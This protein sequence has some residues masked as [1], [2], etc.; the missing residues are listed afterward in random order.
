MNKFVD[1]QVEMEQ[2]VVTC[3]NME[4]PE[5]G[6][7]FTS[8]G[9]SA[10]GK[11]ESAADHDT[12]MVI[13]ADDDIHAVSRCTTSAE[14]A[15]E[16][17]DEG[18]TCLSD[19]QIRDSLAETVVTQ[20]KDI[21]YL[22]TAI[23]ALTNYAEQKEEKVE[24]EKARAHKFGAFTL[25]LRKRLRASLKV[26]KKQ[27]EILKRRRWEF[28]WECEN[29][30]AEIEGMHVDKLNLGDEN[31]RRRRELALHI[32]VL[33]KENA[34]KD[35]EIRRAQAER[36]SAWDLD[37]FDYT[38]VYNRVCQKELDLDEKIKEESDIFIRN[39]EL[40]IENAFLHERLEHLHNELINLQYDQAYYD[41]RKYEALYVQEQ[42]EN[43]K[44]Q[45]RIEA[46]EGEVEELHDLLRQ[47]QEQL[48]ET[49]ATAP[50]AVESIQQPGDVGVFLP[51]ENRRTTAAAQWE[52]AGEITPGSASIT[53]E[54]TSP[55]R[56]ATSSP[57]IMADLQE[58]TVPIADAQEAVATQRRIEQNPTAS[59]GANPPAVGEE[60]AP[61]L[62]DDYSEQKEKYR[63]GSGGGKV[64]IMRLADIY[65]TQDSIDEKFK[66]GGYLRNAV[67]A[68]LDATTAARRRELLE[69]YP[70]IT[71]VYDHNQ[72]CY[73]VDNRR[74]YLLKRFVGDWGRIAVQAFDSPA[75]YDANRPKSSLP[76]LDK[77]TTP[78]L[79]AASETVVDVVKSNSV[80]VRYKLEKDRL[81]RFHEARKKRKQNEE[82][83]RM[84]ELAED[85]AQ[86]E[87]FLTRLFNALKDCSV[88]IRALATEQNTGADEMAE[89]V[90]T[91]RTKH[92][93]RPQNSTTGNTAAWKS[94]VRPPL[95]PIPSENVNFT[96]DAVSQCLPDS[97]AGD[98]T[99]MHPPPVTAAAIRVAQHHGQP[100]F[101]A[102]PS[103]SRPAGSL[104]SNFQT[105]T[106]GFV[107]PVVASLQQGPIATQRTKYH[108]PRPPQQTYGHYSK[109]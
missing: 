108:F 82:Q 29:R 89:T 13:I 95:K 40:Q 92:H 47:T 106:N 39:Q 26:V 7:P 4:G 57:K 93:V 31:E 74:L 97:I 59:A 81:C 12:E 75:A 56:E 27:R 90:D 96:V 30:R 71:V 42:K 14:A 67:I 52:A 9:H 43:A 54:G 38:E 85:L 102:N 77:L 105:T 25:F 86:D 99:P 62:P 80:K 91:E 16:N 63:N 17:E 3:A 32:G 48:N 10:V 23:A 41:R 103:T 8:G 37:M 6:V 104:Y 61:L 46:L 21:A 51:L 66:D 107:P 20:E 87:S 28:E 55:T 19:T 69:R 65:F 84:K 100:Q 76:F 44:N 68:L 45:T 78:N 73:S 70:M 83:E 53:D 50:S 64:V 36:D 72:R 15:D 1:E 58:G 34:D 22:R 88:D 98:G 11:I 33:E 60:L 35:A 79:S 49:L 109:Y 2:E 18:T 101:V 5:K 94:P 24:R